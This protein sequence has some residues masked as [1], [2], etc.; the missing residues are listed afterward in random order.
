MNAVAEF[1]VEAVGVEEREEQLEVLFLA[2][3]GRGRHQKQVAGAGAELFRKLEA[4]G[5]LQLAAEEMRREFVGLVE[6]DEV[7]AGGAK[8]ILKLL[9]A[10]HLVEPDDEMIE[11]FEGIAAGRDGLQVAGEDAEVQARS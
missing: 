7:P 11:V 9:V 3:M 6:H 10:R 8:L 4:A 1:A 2:V 5:L